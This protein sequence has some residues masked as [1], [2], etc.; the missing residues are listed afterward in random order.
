MKNR[1]IFVRFCTIIV[2]LHTAINI[3][4][5]YTIITYDEIIFNHFRVYRLCIG[6]P[7]RQTILRTEVRSSTY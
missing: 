5:I 6:L 4:N 7:L 1:C 3:D 2:Y